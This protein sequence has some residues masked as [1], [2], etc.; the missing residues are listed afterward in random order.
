MRY[1]V[2]WAET[3]VREL[4]KMDRKV[5]KRIIDRVEAIKENPF[6]FVKKLVDLPFY[7]LRVGDYR[8]ILSIDAGKLVIFVVHV[9]HRSKVYKR[10]FQ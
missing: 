8:V 9:G 4:E 10:N 1:E 3:A 2:I 6:R 7:S 5:A